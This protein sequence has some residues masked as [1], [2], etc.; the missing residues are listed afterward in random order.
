MEPY[1][2][3]ACVALAHM[4]RKEL[5][6]TE[7]VRSCL[8][9]IQTLDAK[10]GAWKFLAPEAS[11]ARARQ[12]DDLSP[13]GPLHGLPMGVKDVIDT[14]DMPTEYG[15]PIF[16]GWRPR[17]DAA[18]VSI[19][20]RQGAIV[21]GKTITQAFACG[22]P[23]NTANPLDVNRTAGGSSSGSAAAVAAKMVPLAFGTQSASSLIRPASYCGL[24]GMRP[25]MG[26]IS[27]AGFKYF[28]GSFDTIG[29][30]GRDVDDVELIW[31]TQL[32]LPFTAGILPDRRLKIAICRPPWLDRA[33]K[34]ALDTIDRAQD[35]LAQAGA[36]VRELVLPDAYGSLVQAHER[37]QEFEAARSYS[38][39]YEQ[40]RDMLDARVLEIIENGRRMCAGQYLELLEHANQAR[41]TFENVI[42]DADC[43]ATAAAPGEAPL[44]WHALG[45]KFQN[46]GDTALSRAWTLL[47]VPVVTVPCHR[48]PANMPIGIQFIARFG[49]DQRLLRIARWAEQMFS[50]R[51]TSAGE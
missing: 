46:M 11:I 24:V 27:V 22:M 1:E 18:C 23:V 5:S 9:R 12:L 7:L 20:R 34:S 47:H 38:A 29:L 3:T 35:L 4:R 45:S 25:S 16:S 30:L 19:S 39:E 21:I 42:G 13:V 44:G 36:E 37:M 50:A 31:S 8:D 28:N 15:S 43:I 41:C 26:L 51:I 10:I 6:A 14:S 49:E 33:E 2:L 17:T 32:D 40:H 48:G